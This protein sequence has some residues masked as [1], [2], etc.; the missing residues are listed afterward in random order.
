MF[1]KCRQF[2]WLNLANLYNLNLV[3]C[4]ASMAHF[5]GKHKKTGTL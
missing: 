5:N 4:G 3:F 1:V 2:C